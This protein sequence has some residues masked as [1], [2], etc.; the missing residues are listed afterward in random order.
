MTC[1]FVIP[2][3]GYYLSYLLRLW[4]TGRQPAWYASPESVTGEPQAFLR[5]QT[6]AEEVQ[7]ENKETQ[8]KNQETH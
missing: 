5:E 8:L 1:A 3:S 6:G 2:N 7:A 4:Q